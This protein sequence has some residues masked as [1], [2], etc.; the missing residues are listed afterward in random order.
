MKTK[1]TP[2]D[3]ARMISTEND[4]TVAPPQAAP[5]KEDM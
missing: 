5:I 2:A 4:I 1:L 3:E